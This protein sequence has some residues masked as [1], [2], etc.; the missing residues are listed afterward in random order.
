M[1]RERTG[2]IG[3]LVGRLAGASAIVVFAHADGARDIPNSA[4][5]IPM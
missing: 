4:Q 1:G 2:S 3:H 5:T